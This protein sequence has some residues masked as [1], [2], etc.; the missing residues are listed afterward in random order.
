M[1][2]RYR[3]FL[4]AQTWDSTTSTLLTVATDRTHAG[5]GL[6]P[7]T[8][9]VS[10]SGRTVCSLL[11]CAH[12]RDGSSQLLV[13]RR[14]LFDDNFGVDEALNEPGLSWDGAGLVVRGTHRV[15]L[16][17]AAAA[18]A[19]Q[20]SMQQ[21]AMYPPRRAYANLVESPAGMR[22]CR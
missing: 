3:G 18:P 17:S 2:D 20:K 14:L 22:R 10:T 5:T 12:S 4:W 11:V 1:H 7:G 16:T 19:A 21:D 13:H 8:L 6:N 9:D 15:A